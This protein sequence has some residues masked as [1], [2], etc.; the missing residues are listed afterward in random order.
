MRRFTSAP[1]PAAVRTA[2]QTYAQRLRGDG[3]SG[4]VQGPHGQ[5][6][7]LSLVAE[8][9]VLRHLDAVEVEL[10]ALVLQD[11]HGEGKLALRIDDPAYDVRALVAEEQ[12]PEHLDL[13]VGAHAQ[14]AREMRPQ[15]M[16][17]AP[18]VTPPV[19]PGVG[20]RIA[21]EDRLERAPQ[22]VAQR[23]VAA[24][25]RVVAL[26][27]LGGHRRAPED[28]LVA[29]VAPVQHLAGDRVV[30]GLG[31]L[32][33]PVLVQQR[34]V[35]ELD[36]RPQRLVGLGLGKAVDERA[37]GLL[38]ARVVH[39]DARARERLDLAPRGAL[40]EPPRLDRRLAEQPI[41]AVEALEDGAR[42]A[43]GGVYAAASFGFFCESKNCSS[44]V[45]P[46][47]AVVDALPA[48]TTCVIS[49]K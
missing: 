17:D 11:R 39:L 48:V 29:V 23:V 21:V 24:V 32:G 42:D 25:G 47:S 12:R 9:P 38:D 45:E 33:L 28:E 41:V 40:V 15:G 3:G 30:E 35:G 43:R 27:V 34:D 49:S 36:R 5:G 19:L 37:H 6:E 7:P 1:N 26:E 14:G 2:A 8:D 10:A 22:A 31:A 13:Q 44:S 20:E 4:V 18:Q 16:H 46:C